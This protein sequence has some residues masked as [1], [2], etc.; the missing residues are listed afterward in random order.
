MKDR[1]AVELRVHLPA[2]VNTRSQT[3]TNIRAWARTS[4][5]SS[6]GMHIKWDWKS[7]I[8]QTR[9]FHILQES[10]LR[11]LLKLT[12]PFS[13][14]RCRNTEAS[15][16]QTNVRG[17][18]KEREPPTTIRLEANHHFDGPLGEPG[19]GPCKRTDKGNSIGLA[20][21]SSLLISASS[22]NP[23]QS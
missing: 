3:S 9:A 12:T 11:T 14:D 21:S 6:G 10:G 5:R 17:A 15:L 1:G 8:V 18:E 13:H 20:Q 16:V 7:S 4:F 2:L 19:P 23:C 22:S